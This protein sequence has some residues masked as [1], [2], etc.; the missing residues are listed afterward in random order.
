MACIYVP[1]SRVRYRCIWGTYGNMRFKNFQIADTIDIGTLN[2]CVILSLW[3]SNSRAVHAS[4]QG[5]RFAST[6][7]SYPSESA[8]VKVGI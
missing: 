8:A 5:R 3:I 6:I 4:S 2:I 1:L 7:S